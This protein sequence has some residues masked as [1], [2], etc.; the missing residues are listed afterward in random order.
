VTSSGIDSSPALLARAALAF[1]LAAPSLVA[2][3][4]TPRAGARAGGTVPGAPPALAAPPV[5]A[6]TVLDNGV[7]V[8]IE[9][10]HV[11]PVVAVEVWVASGAA[12]DPPALAGAAHF[13]EH[14][15]LRGGKRRQ[16]GAGARELD[17]VKGAVGAWTGLDETVYHALVAAPFVE[18]ALD[19]LADQIANPTF[20]AAEI[21]RVRKLVL[22]E[23]TA[24]A[25]DSRARASQAL[26]AAAFGGGRYAQPVMGTAAAVAA[27]TPAS[28]AAHFPETHGAEALTVVVVGDVDSNAVA[29]VRRAF[30]A[31]P[32]GRAGAA[33]AL[34]PG[35]PG[36]VTLT[37][38]GRSPAEMVVGFRSKKLSVKEVAAL[39]LLAAVLARGE[40]ARMPR[41]IVRNRQLADG[42]R[43]F[44]FRARDAG[45][46]GFAVTPAPRRLA[47][48]AA[49]V[50][51]VALRAASEPATA[52]ELE[53]ARAA[54][55]GDVA[56]A[57]DGPLGRARRLGFA[58]AIARDSDDEKEYLET[59]ARI[60]P[61][62]LQQIAGEIL[63]VGQLTLAVALPDGRPAGSDETPA[64]LGPRLDAIVAAAPGL[65]EARAPGA[66]L[67]G[68]GGQGGKSDAVRFVTP[69]GVRGIVVSDGSAPLVS[70]Q[71]AW[72]D[73]RDEAAGD[74]AAPVIAALLEAGTRTRSRG[75][76]ADEVRA[77]GGTLKGFTAPGALGLRADF[78]PQHLS[79]GL[80]LVADCVAHPAFAEREV[81]AVERSSPARDDARVAAAGERGALRLFRET[82]WPDVPG[83][84]E[85]DAAPVLGRFALLDRYRRR[86]PLSRL[87]VAVVGNV[88]PAVVA[89]ALARAF[90]GAPASPPAAAPSPPPAPAV[91]AE[92][93]TEG[94]TTVFR[95]V[96][97]TESTAVIGYPAPTTGEATRPPVEVLAEVLTGEGGRLTTA[98][99]DERT[100]GCRASARLASAGAPGYLAVVVRC[101]PA[102][103]DA[104]VAAVRAALARLASS[105]VTPDEVTRAARGLIG[106]RAAALRTRAA[107]ADALVRDEAAGLPLR[108]Y[109]QAPAGLARVTP[110]DVARA[111]QAIIDPKREI[112][113]V[114]HPP[115]AAPALARAPGAAN[116]PGRG[117]SER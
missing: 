2:G 66:P 61:D 54:L 3:C 40:G 9:E 111:A 45:L 1:A 18:L 71:A 91:R 15:V 48:A 109:R 81:D 46:V 89:A 98:L 23:I 44:S 115:S 50:L 33:A 69:S 41:E 53:G 57:G 51:D 25:G 116:R 70:V 52:D 97:G 56:R 14:L 49:A 85:L 88:D 58:A 20:D 94:P 102:R 96:G 76:M 99:G 36:H 67:V 73:R 92:G 11:T 39:D 30:G 31:I 35:K 80:A 87:I 110:A 47:E 112:I 104:A 103:L 72:I 83:H 8:V 24:G 16:A 26:F 105:A 13:Y 38:G 7:R 77:I 17:A 84:A 4:G 117:E 59:I 29:A 37:S 21:E 22:D 42:V 114:I 60:G 107:V 62:E 65:A 82:L 12:D 27:L 75:D 100:L 79:R 63:N 55:Q 106:A 93:Q 108:T 95:A 34:V 113:A 64:V 78:L 101:P 43:P 6:E 28:L 10:N 90:A 68:Q 19:V 32:R 74:D 5:R 86:Y